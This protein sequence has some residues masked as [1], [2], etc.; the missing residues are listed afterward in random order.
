[1]VMNKNDPVGAS[2]ASRL[3]E[4]K[5]LPSRNHAKAHAPLP[6]LPLEAK[7]SPNLIAVIASEYQARVSA[8]RKHLRVLSVEVP[9]TD[10]AI[11]S[12]VIL[13]S[14]PIL[15]S[16][17]DRS[18]LSTNSITS[19]PSP[20]ARSGLRYSAMLMDPSLRSPASLTTETPD[21]SSLTHPTSDLLSCT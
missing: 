18:L 21:E 8:S 14:P 16:K 15:K 4:P 13:P 20:I 19:S 2:R 10:S 6:P 7:S 17:S 1:M 3:P 5:L 12:P 9:E 11:S